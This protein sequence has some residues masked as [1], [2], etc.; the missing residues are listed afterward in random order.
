MSALAELHI[1]HRVTPS[2]ECGIALY[3]KPVFPTLCICNTP[4]PLYFVSV[5]RLGITIRLSSVF[6]SVTVSVH[7]GIF[8]CGR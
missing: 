2:R 3:L 6:V 5:F 4:F 8:V 1:L 7:I